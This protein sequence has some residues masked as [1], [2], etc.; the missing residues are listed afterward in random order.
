M[1]PTSPDVE[2]W[3]AR[4]GIAG[5]ILVALAVPASRW[6]WLLYL[7][8]NLC[9]LVFAHRNSYPKLLRQSAVF[10]VATLLG[11]LNAF[12]PGNPVQLTLQTLL[13]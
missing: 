4:F 11:I 7:G 13:A 2:A 12:W 6:G 10:T 9:W 1:R 5:A 8:S 3:G